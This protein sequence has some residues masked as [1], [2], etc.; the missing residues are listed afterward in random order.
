VDFVCLKHRLV[1]EIDGGQH[2]LNVGAARDALR[3]ARLNESGF[4]VL[5]FWNSDVDRDLGGVLETID[6]ALKES[7]PHPAAVGGHPPP[8]GEG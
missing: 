6:R 8:S 3:D 7:A 5:Q 2:N 4:R 1:V